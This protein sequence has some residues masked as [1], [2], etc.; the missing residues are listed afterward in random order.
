MDPGAIPR[1]LR[2]HLGPA[3][4]SFSL[5]LTHMGSVSRQCGLFPLACPM[6]SLGEHDACHVSLPHAHNATLQDHT[7]AS[8][9]QALLGSPSATAYWD[10]G[11]WNADKANVLNPPVVGCASAGVKEGGAKLS[12]HLGPCH[13]DWQSVL[14]LPILQ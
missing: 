7:T 9:C 6:G 1:G 13:R 12:D 11:K 5:G 4:I 14:L 3:F 2:Q 10:G 8:S